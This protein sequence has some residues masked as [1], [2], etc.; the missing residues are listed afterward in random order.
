VQVQVSAVKDGLILDAKLETRL[1][2]DKPPPLTFLG[3]L[4]EE[5]YN[6]GPRYKLWPVS[7]SIAWTLIF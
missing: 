4:L 5:V 2:L 3:A 1:T 6:L 7:V